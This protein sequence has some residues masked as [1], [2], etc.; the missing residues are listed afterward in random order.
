MAT[1]TPSTVPLL[2]L[3]ILNVTASA[4]STIQSPTVSWASLRT[5]PLY[6]HMADKTRFRSGFVIIVSCVLNDHLYQYEENISIQEVSYLPPEFVRH[7]LS[8]HHPLL[9]HVNHFSFKTVDDSRT[10][11][12]LLDDAKKTTVG[13]NP[14]SSSYTPR[15]DI[16]SYTHECDP[17]DLR[18]P[19]TLSRSTIRF[20]ALRY[21]SRP[22]CRL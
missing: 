5:A 15:H 10:E 18:Q 13:S 14:E 3:L 2:N 6:I 17:A 22:K 20:Q 7:H 8:R 21:R 19:R 1:S 4:L 11:L 9:S 16:R 12:L